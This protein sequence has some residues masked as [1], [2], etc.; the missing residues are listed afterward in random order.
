MSGVEHGDV[1]D[2]LPSLEADFGHAAVVDFPW[3]FNAD[4]GSGRF[5]STGSDREFEVYQTEENDRLADVLDALSRVLVDGA[6]VFVFADDDTVPE[7]RECVEESPFTYRRTCVWDR[8]KFGMGYYHRV[9]HYP[10]LTATNG[11]TDRYIQGRG[12]VYRALKHDGEAS[13]S[14]YPTGKPVKLYRQMLA[15]PVL[16]DGERLLEPFCGHGPGAAVAAERGIDYWGADTNPEAVEQ[17]RQ[18]LEQTRL[19][20]GL[21]TATDGGES[22]STTSGGADR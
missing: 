6:W 5:E 10:I 13:D 21:V 15:E 1:F 18:H 8:E 9:Q 22:P 2:L 3:Q 17:A 4:N 11:E 20:E 16:D 19:T 7:F 14:D 12:T